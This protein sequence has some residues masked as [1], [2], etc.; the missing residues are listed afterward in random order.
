MKKKSY[1]KAR[2]LRISDENYEKLED[3]KK[4]NKG[5][6]NYFFNKLIQ[7]Y[8]EHDKQTARNE[9][10]ESSEKS[11]SSENNER[12]KSDIGTDSSCEGRI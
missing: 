7:K 4:K 1:H 12:A 3:L 5:T 2:H 8:G 9:K 11:S 6:W 10:E